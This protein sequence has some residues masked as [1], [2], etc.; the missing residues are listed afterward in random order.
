MLVAFAKAGA[1]VRWHGQGDLVTLEKAVIRGEV[2]E[3]M[4]CACSE[5]GLE[6]LFPAKTADEV[7]DLKGNY[8]AR[9]NLASALGLDDVIYDIDNKSMTHRPDLWSHYGLARDIAAVL[10]LPLKQYATDNRSVRADARK[11][12]FKVRVAEPKLCPR[13][14]AVLIE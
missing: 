3:G 12:T 5:I 2:S 13:Y 7:I 8:E 1:K 11:A 4:I 10:D 14:M 9:E 6:N